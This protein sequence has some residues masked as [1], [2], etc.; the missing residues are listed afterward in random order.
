MGGRKR[1]ERERE[2]PRSAIRSFN[3]NKAHLCTCAELHPP[4]STCSSFSL[5]L[6]QTHSLGS[7]SLFHCICHILFLSYSRLQSLLPNEP[8]HFLTTVL[9]EFFRL[10]LRLSFSFH[11]SF[12]SL[13]LTS[14]PFSR[15][16]CS[17]FLIIL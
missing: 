5:S 16:L 15:F 10:R 1:G 3:E 6:S 17:A 2:V 12:T 9:H 4:T 7:L 8:N 11:L 14:K 13:S